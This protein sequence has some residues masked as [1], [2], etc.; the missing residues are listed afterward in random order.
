VPNLD[1]DDLDGMIAS[2]S[3]KRPKRESEGRSRR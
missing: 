1:L 2:E 3:R